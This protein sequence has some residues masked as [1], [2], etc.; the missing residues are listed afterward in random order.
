MNG[1]IDNVEFRSDSLVALNGLILHFVSSLQIPSKITALSTVTG[2]RTAYRGG[3]G[4][5]ICIYLCP[6]SIRNLR[7]IQLMTH[8]Y[9]DIYWRPRMVQL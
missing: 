8:E 5:D 6:R 7:S 4:V 2:S 9:N 1:P 3:A